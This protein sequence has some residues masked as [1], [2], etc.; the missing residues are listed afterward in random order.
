MTIQK[1]QFTDLAELLALQK[2]C[3]FQEAIIYNDY[4]IPPLVQTMVSIEEDFKQQIFLKLVNNQQIIGSVRGYTTNEV[5]KIGRL[6]VHPNFQNRGLG[7]KLMAAIE[8]E[9]LTV[10]NYELF[11][12]HQS[13]KNLNFYKK[14]GYIEFQRQPIHNNLIL[15]YLVK[16]NPYKND[17]TKK[18]KER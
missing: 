9:F 6:I 13:Q 1:V 2:K 10:D 16:N 18:I 12:G 11:T 7:K 5:C 4:Q 14:L 3:Y 8:Q 17:K 15:I